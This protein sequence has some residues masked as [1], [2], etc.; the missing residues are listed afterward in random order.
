MAEITG[1]STTHVERI[2]LDEVYAPPDD[3]NQPI[4]R[5]MD[6]TKFVWTLEKQAL[7]F[8]RADQLGDRF[9][10]SF[11]RVNLATRREFWGERYEGP[12]ALALEEQWREG[13]LYHFINSWHMNEHESAAM[14]RLYL[15]SDEGI[16]IRS[17]YKR[18]RDSTVN[19]PGLPINLLT[20]KYLDYETEG[21][22][23]ENEPLAPFAFKRK[24]FEH[25]REL[26]AV[27]QAVDYLLAV[28]TGAT[29]PKLGW[30]VEV[31][32]GTLI[33]RVYVAP[34]TAEWVRETVEAVTRK[35][36]LDV[37]VRRSDLSRD[38]VY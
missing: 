19:F 13:P 5:Y 31:P 21:A 2:A 37:E 30:V 27:M 16:A 17:T 33:E 1:T 6:F 15:K 36:G 11:T 29:M 34:T 25:E 8:S 14:W 38:P 23:P 3:E 9:E 24:T 10:G 7:W 32:L 18:L 28:K 4:W 22:I 12:L 35:Y 26:R 20:V